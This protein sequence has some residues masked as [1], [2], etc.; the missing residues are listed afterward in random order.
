MKHFKCFQ[1]VL[2]FPAS[3]VEWITEGEIP[4]N[5]LHEDLT[6][7]NQKV[8]RPFIKQ[9]YSPLPQSLGEI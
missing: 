5:I 9:L 8:E 4:V 3:S 6:I 1:I 7:C 2:F